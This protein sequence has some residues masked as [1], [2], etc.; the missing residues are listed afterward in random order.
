MQ[1]IIKKPLNILKLYAFDVYLIE[2][3]IIICASEIYI[4]LIMKIIIPNSC[5]EKKV[6]IHL[7]FR[8][9]DA[10]DRYS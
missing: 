2:K 5:L 3:S 4:K 6:K 7:E 8:F 9:T 10:T 1:I